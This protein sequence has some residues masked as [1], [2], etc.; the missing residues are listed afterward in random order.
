LGGTS[1]VLAVTIGGSVLLADWPEWRGPNRDGVA[2]ARNLPASWSPQG[3]NLA[4]RVPIGGRSGPVVFGD[5]LYLQTGVGTGDAAQERVVALDA[6][7]GKLVWEHR[8]PVYLT[9]VPA[10]RTG[11]ASPSVDPATGHVFT[12]GVNGHLACFGPDGKILWQRS[13]VEDYGFVTTHG[14]RTVSPIIEGDLLIINSLNVGWGELGRGGNRW[15]AFDKATGQTVWVSSPQKKHYDTNMSPGIVATINGARLLIVGGTDGAF[16]A[17][18]VNTGEPVWE[19]EFS[20]RAI[21]TG[22]VLKDTTVYLTHSEEN[23]DT[24]DMGMI[25]AVDA[26]GTGTLGRE[27]TKW[28]VHGFQGGFSSP[29]LDGDRLYQVD[30]GAILAAFDLTTGKKLWEKILGTIQKASP[31]LADGKLYVGTENGK[32][33]ILRPGATGVEV[34]DEDWLGSEAAPEAITGSPAVSGGRV[35][36]TSIEATYAIGASAKA[37]PARPVTPTPEPPSTAEPTVVQVFPYELAL[38]PGEKATFTARLFDAKGRF[39]RED[40]ATWSL[41]QLGG[42]ITDGV[43]TAPADRAGAAGYVKATVGTIAGQARVRVLPEPP[44][45]YDFE[46]WTGEVAPRH[47]INTTNKLFVRDLDGNKVLVRVPD[48]TPQRR[49][50]VFIG[51]STWSNLTVEADVRSTERRRT[52]SDVGVFNQRFGLVLFGNSQKIELQPWQAAAARSVSVPFAWKPD[53]WYHVK[54]RVENKPGG[55][56]LAQGKVWPRGETEPAAWTIEKL[57]PIGHRE[58]SPGLYADPN[59]EVYF[60]NLKVT[61]NQ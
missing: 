9:D 26:T 28:F 48:A 29:V 32:F 18:K 13:L 5:R 61:A 41:D 3:E 2:D 60:D 19:Y 37:A 44:L 50:R 24:S 35:Y 46:Q 8:F 16:H 4:W 52:L 40:K 7:T 22:A 39:V 58:G 49:T 12:H 10:H 6:N 34:L 11:W 43:Y 45:S 51:R 21:L 31:V 30:N 57:D 14:G 1:L 53:T 54:L 27:Q 59:S 55:A 15:F 47:W 17:L 20:K 56:T 23:L 33:Y 25:A 42:T 36:V 38:K